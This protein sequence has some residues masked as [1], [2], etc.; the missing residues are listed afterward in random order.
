[1][2][3]WEKERGREKGRRGEGDKQRREEERRRA[4]EMER[5]GIA[6]MEKV[7]VRVVETA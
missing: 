2:K 4:G 3:R 5:F 1:M 6:G 7:V